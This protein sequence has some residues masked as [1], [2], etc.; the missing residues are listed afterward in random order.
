[1]GQQQSLCVCHA[2]PSN[3]FKSIGNSNL[4]VWAE[5]EPSPSIQEVD[6]KAFCKKREGEKKFCTCDIINLPQPLSSGVG[7]GEYQVASG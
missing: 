7:Y 1:M 6:T 2:I 5:P 4:V 3:V